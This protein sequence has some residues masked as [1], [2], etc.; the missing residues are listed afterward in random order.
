MNPFEYRK[1][2]NLEEAFTLLDQYG[3]RASILAGG[4]DL[5]VKMR[6][7]SLRPDLLIDL[8]GIPGLDQIRYDPSVGLHIGALTTIHSLEDSPLIQDHFQGIAQAAGSLG[9][10]QVRCRATL[11]GNICNASPAA[12]MVPVLLALEAQA[13]IA[14]KKEERWMPLE[15]IFA[16]PGRTHLQAGDLLLEIHIPQTGGPVLTRYT[17]HGI[18]QAMDLTIASV[19]VALWP[20]AEKTVCFQARLA[21][22]SVGPVALRAYK[23]EELLRGQ[24]LDEKVISRVA[25][26]ASEEARPITDIRGSAEYRRE[27][28]QVLTRRLLTK[29]WMDLRA[30]EGKDETFDSANGER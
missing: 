8:K 12:D 26:L 23:A 9:S 11:G 18:R 13:K 1:I 14:G 20:A 10:Y 28:V 3:D 7:K 29:T 21:L 16:G 22:G 6:H 27:M 17:K 25:E 5:L 30:L 2:S 19:A 24:K 4:T 15:K